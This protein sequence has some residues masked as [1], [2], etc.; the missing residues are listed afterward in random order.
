MTVEAMADID[1]A[2]LGPDALFG[3]LVRRRRGGY[4]MNRTG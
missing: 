1:V 2:D 3:K 4:S